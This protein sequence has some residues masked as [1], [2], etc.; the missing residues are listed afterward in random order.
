MFLRIYTLGRIFILCLLFACSTQLGFG[1]FTNEKEVFK[2]GEEEF[3]KF[4]NENIEFPSSSVNKKIQGLLIYSLT[5]NP[6]G[7]IDAAF[8]T[9]LDSDIEIEAAKLLSES[10]RFYVIKNRP[11]TVYHTMVFSIGQFDMNDFKVDSFKTD[12][13]FPWI[14]PIQVYARL[15]SVVTK[16]KIGTYTSRQAA[17]NQVNRLDNMYQISPN[18]PSTFGTLY[19]IEDHQQVYQKSLDKLSRSLKKGK[20][21]K[22][23]EELNVLIRLNP[24]NIEHLQLR[25]KLESELGLSDYKKYDEALITILEKK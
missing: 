16:Q 4:I 5:V 3:V 22:A 20:Q 23:L 14:K 18:N 17:Q 1:Q 8:L 15:Y 13:E 6:N 25:R 12:F 10:T 2:N 9:K 19:D 7:V 11:Y 21:N 24:F